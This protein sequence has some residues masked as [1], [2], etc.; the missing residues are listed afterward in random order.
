MTVLVLLTLAYATGIALGQI[1]P[2]PAWHALATVPCIII[3]LAVSVGCRRRLALVAVVGMLVLGWGRAPVSNARPGITG[4]QRPCLRLIQ[5]AI[6]QAPLSLGDQTRLVMDLESCSDCVDAPGDARMRPAGGRL[7][8]TVMKGESLRISHGEIVRILV[9]PRP[10]QDH[11]NPGVSRPARDGSIFTGFAHSSSE[12]VRI[13]SP[14][15]RI[16][17]LLD[18]QRRELAAFWEGALGERESRLARALTLGE[19]RALHR[20]QRESFRRT[21]AAHLL[22]VSGLHLAIV[23]LIVFGG[24]RRILLWIGPVSRRWDVGKIAAL[25]AI[26]AIVAFAILVGGR[27]PVVR[28]CVMATGVLLARFLGRKGGARES[29]CLAGAG[30]LAFEPSN[31]VSAGF[32]LS[33]S[34]VLGF[35]SMSYRSPV[36][37]MEEGSGIRPAC[38][39]R[40]FAKNTRRSIRRLF[41]ST[42]AATAATTPVILYHFGTISLVS[43][44]VNMMVVPYTSFLLMPWLLLVSCTAL[45]SPWL[46]GGLA[47]PAGRML[48]LL[49]DLLEWISG[50]PCT[51]E[52]TDFPHMVGISLLCLAV[53]LLLARRFKATVVV[54]AISAGLMVI[55][56]V[57]APKS[58]PA[59]RLT[60]DFL[61]VGQGDATL[62]TFPDGRHWLVDAGGTATGPETVGERH[63]VPILR[64]LGVDY[65]DT[66]VLTHPDP[67]HV[68]GMPAIFAS[69]CVGGLWDNGQGKA[70]GAHPAYDEVIAHCAAHSIP[71]SRGRSICGTRMVAG[72]RVDLLHPCH[73]NLEYDPGLSF[74]DNSLVMHLS[75]G[76]TS[77]LL[78]GDL[79]EEGE[80]VLMERGAVPRSD[81]LKLGHHGSRNSSTRDFLDLVRPSIG[82]ASC[83]LGN[84]YGMPHRDV[85]RRLEERNVRLFRTDLNGAV[86]IVSD[87]A[88][89]YTVPMKSG[90]GR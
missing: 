13:E 29:V 67:D 6:S 80:R 18:D 2:V 20:E 22:A 50:L 25:L 79:G 28:A 36:E 56:H 42:L 31:I 84:R 43:I 87:A 8:L 19:S 1:F 52:A 45:V 90:K 83:G 58:F 53:F 61:D 40:R 3:V 23:A 68:T 35:L 76:R 14:S 27:A 72:V 63:L 65:L 26:P 59:N 54:V 73:D 32:Q 66:V 30:L 10:V 57:A 9:E 17:D 48:G 78:A 46:A 15:P 39:V 11:R 71:I 86:R 74:N 38:V 49:E 77:F 51:L 60:I 62:V 89:I 64:G 69:I 41:M 81:V 85:R 5:G 75:Y 12:I 33:F 82:V 47:F 44:P 21:G 7:Y 37:A 24:I 4:G 88:S 34:A 55:A 16:A 70:E